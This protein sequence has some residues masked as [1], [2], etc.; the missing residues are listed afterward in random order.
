MRWARWDTQK[1]GYITMNE[2]N[3]GG[4]RK[5]DIPMSS[6]YQQTLDKIKDLFKILDEM[7][8]V[9]LYLGDFA[10]QPLP[11]NFVMHEHVESLKMPRTKLFLLSSRRIGLL[12]DI[13]DDLDISPPSCSR[14]CLSMNFDNLLDDSQS[15]FSSVASSSGLIGTSSERQHL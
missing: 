8:P 10:K 4:Q 7:K 15:S 14:H 1:S 5:I 11:R 3:G 12:P 13:D 6:D 2:N 9:N